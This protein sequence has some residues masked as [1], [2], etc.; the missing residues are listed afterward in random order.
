LHKTGRWDVFPFFIRLVKT[1]KRSR[2]DV[3]Y[4]FLPMANIMAAVALLFLSGVRLVWGIRSSDMQVGEY[5]YFAQMEN[6]IERLLSKQA[7][8]I[9]CNSWAG[10]QVCIARG[11]LESRLA[12]IG[13]GVDT[14]RYQFDAYGRRN[15]RQQWGVDE[16]TFVIG[17]VARLD[18][19]KGYEYFLLAAQ[20]FAQTHPQAVFWCIGQGDA[21]YSATLYNLTEQYGL[22]NRLRWCGVQSDLAP[23]YSAFDVLTS[24]S[25]FGEGF[26]NSIAEAMACERVCVVTDVGDSARMIGDTG[27]VVPPRQE[28]AIVEA[29][30]KAFRMDAQERKA[31]GLRARH[32][33]V[34]EMSV[35]SMVQKSAALLVNGLEQ[36]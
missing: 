32:R 2:P 5:G 29:W 18:R 17:I 36:Q 25:I 7:D 22:A 15:V 23:I 14:Q 12:V 4:S 28:R 11:F 9:V 8:K 27:W 19:M 21:D 34:D 24:T 31:M 10:R 33:A 20:Q 6:C 35:A 16:N 30:D 13:N 1:I 3:I 26:S